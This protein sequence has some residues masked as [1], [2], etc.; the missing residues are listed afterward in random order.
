M[1]NPTLELL[2]NS[3][4]VQGDEIPYELYTFYKYLINY[5]DFEL[6]ENETEFYWT[7]FVNRMRGYKHLHISTNA[8]LD[9]LR[10]SPYLEILGFHFSR[11]SYRRVVCQVNFPIVISSVRDL[12]EIPHFKDYMRRYIHKKR[13]TVFN[14]NIRFINE[15]FENMENL[16]EWMEAA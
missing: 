16:E 8:S 1:S 6:L 9:R 5:V 4:V 3:E 10:I 7:E 11:E 13:P 15:Y 14:K 12:L 2:L